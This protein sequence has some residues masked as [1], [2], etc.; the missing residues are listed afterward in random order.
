MW[1]YLSGVRPPSESEK[2]KRK[3]ESTKEYYKGYD[4]DKRARKYLPEWEKG[5]PWL[6]YLDD[7][8][9]WQGLIQDFKLGGVHL[10]K[11][12]RVEGG[13]KMFGTFCVKNHDFMPRNHIFSNCGG[14]RESFW[15][16]SCEKS[17][18]YAKKSYFFTLDPPLYG[19]YSVYR[20]W[21][22]E[23]YVCNWLYML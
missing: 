12:R 6:K 17:R 21:R 10:K 11:L 23:W 19:M 2:K 1:N 15:G 20:V 3:F 7:N 9:V 5:R 4:K 18:S 22:A 16:I 14:R 13:S 8:L